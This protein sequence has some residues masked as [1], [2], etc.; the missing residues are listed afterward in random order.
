MLLCAD[1]STAVPVMFLFT[2]HAELTIEDWYVLTDQAKQRRNSVFCTDTGLVAHD[3][4]TGALTGQ[5]PVVL[6]AEGG[7]VEAAGGL[8]LEEEDALLM[9][10]SEADFQYICLMQLRGF[11]MRE[12]NKVIHHLARACIFACIRLAHCV[13]ALAFVSRHVSFVLDAGP[14][15]R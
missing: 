6:G 15:W 10:L 13:Y 2:L 9:E 7:V 5:P 4:E 11:L 8:L 14:S 1:A 12:S 3:N